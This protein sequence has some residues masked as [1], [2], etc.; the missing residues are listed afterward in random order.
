[1]AQVLDATAKVTCPHAAPLV[2]QA[3]AKLTVGGANGVL[4]QSSVEKASIP[5]CTGHPPPAGVICKK[6]SVT[7]GQAT[8]LAVNGD[9]VLLASLVA[10][11]NGTPTTPVTVVPGTPGKLSAA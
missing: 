5:A 2:M 1:M 7:S 11:T 9:P 10:A 3:A 8:K 4:T 6:A